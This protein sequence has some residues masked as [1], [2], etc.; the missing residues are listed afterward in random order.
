MAGYN[1]L[2]RGNVLKAAH[3]DLFSGGTQKARIFIQQVDNKIADAAGAIHN[4][5]IQYTVSLLRG[6]AA[7]WALNHTD[8]EGNTTFQIYKEFRKAFLRRFTDLNPTGT[9]IEK[10]LNLKQGRMG[11]QEYTMKVLNLVH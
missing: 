4:R 7:E 10:M 3:P 11:I 8:N 6:L 1:P 9:A 2:G 5:K